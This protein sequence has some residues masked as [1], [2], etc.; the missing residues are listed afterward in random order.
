MLRLVSAADLASEDGHRAYLLQAATALCKWLLAEDPD[1][2]VHRI[3]WWQIQ[4]RLGT[5]RS[6]C[7][8]DAIS[9]QLD[10]L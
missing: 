7:L 10:V 5:L 8:I 9:A 2:L 6:D 4:Y 1:S 3:N